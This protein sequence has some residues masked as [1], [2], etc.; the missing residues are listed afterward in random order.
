MTE[1]RPPQ[2][3]DETYSDYLRQGEFR[4]QQCGACQEFVFHPRVL[5]PHCGAAAL[6]WKPAS[7][8]GAVYSCTTVR[9]K[10]DRGGDYNIC[11]VE[12]EE[13]PRMMS[14]IADMP[15][16]D[17]AIGMRVTARIGSENGEPLVLFAPV[18]GAPA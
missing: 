15:T 7:G 17:V 2:G 5:C 18:A 10:A 3:P 13:G 4:L 1:T 16:H 14:R 9:R 12:L 11:I 8:R 6:E